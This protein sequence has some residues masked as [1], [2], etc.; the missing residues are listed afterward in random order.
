MKIS[1]E[2]I[3]NQRIRIWTQRLNDEYQQICFTFNLKLR[4][5]LIKID[6]HGMRWGNWDPETRSLSISSHLI[7]RYPWEIVLEVFKHE[8]AHQLVTEVYKQS[9]IHGPFFKQACLKMGVASWAAKA[10]ITSVPE[11]S[12]ADMGQVSS[13][14]KRLL[15]RVEK[16]LSL[17]TSDNENEALLAMRKVQELYAKYNLERVQKKHEAQWGY[18]V[19]RLNKKRVE[20]YQS[21]IASILNDHFFVEVIHSSLF[22]AVACEDYKVLELLGTRENVLMAEYVFWFLMN[23]LHGL[24]EGFRRGKTGNLSSKNSFF[25]GVL[26]GF[27][28]KLDASETEIQQTSGPNGKSII[29][30]L[31]EDKGL[32]DYLVSRHP[33]LNRLRGGRRFHDAQAFTQGKKEGKSLVLHRAIHQSTGY[34][35]K[36]LK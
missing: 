16:L 9:D 35:K 7:Q 32:N 18:L 5:P 21:V 11:K 26:A 19:I 17:A 1:Q 31:R 22:D 30:W 33:K 8:M 15:E 27:R 36:L 24:W 20:R 10:E 2:A 12:L 4:R 34:Q 3:E 25:L 23:Q 14:E 6:E 29:L 28:Q 13:E